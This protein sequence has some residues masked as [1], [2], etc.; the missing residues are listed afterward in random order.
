MARMSIQDVVELLSRRGRQRE[1]EE[2]LAEA[3]AEIDWLR[4]SLEDA[5]RR[6]T[7]V[8]QLRADEQAMWRRRLRLARGEARR[9]RRPERDRQAAY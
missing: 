3:Y 9:H 8:E 6:L 5:R 1:L 4:A 7:P 2:R